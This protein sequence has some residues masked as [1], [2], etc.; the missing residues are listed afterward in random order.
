MRPHRVVSALAK[1][2]PRGASPIWMKT[3]TAACPFPW[4]GGGRPGEDCLGPSG[5]EDTTNVARLLVPVEGSSRVQAPAWAGPPR[6]GKEYSPR[7]TWRRARRTLD[8]PSEAPP[9]GPKR[10]RLGPHEGRRGGAT[11]GPQKRG[12][13]Y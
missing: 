10:G 7:P 3:G 2:P 8:A 6:P 11:A 5:E 12:A 13:S 1:G 9:G 4:G